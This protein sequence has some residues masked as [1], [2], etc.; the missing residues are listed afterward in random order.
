MAIW[1]IRLTTSIKELRQTEK[2]VFQAYPLLKVAK[3]V[4]QTLAMPALFAGAATHLP[5]AGPVVAGAIG[6]GTDFIQ[7]NLHG[8]RESQ[9]TK[10]FSDLREKH[11]ARVTLWGKATRL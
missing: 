8:L 3:P 2:E 7:N 10:H 6:H 1:L 5:L 11:S 4:V 9:V